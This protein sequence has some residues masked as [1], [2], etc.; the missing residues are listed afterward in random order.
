MIE[1]P[2]DIIFTVWLNGE[3]VKEI[4]NDYQ[5]IGL[6]HAKEPYQ[7][8]END[9]GTIYSGQGAYRRWHERREEIINPLGAANRKLKKRR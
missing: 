6:M 2:F 8:I 4:S 3:F 9:T 1:N 5:I 7:F